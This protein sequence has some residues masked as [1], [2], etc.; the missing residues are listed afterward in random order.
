[1][2]TYY[3]LALAN[4]ACVGA[5]QNGETT[6]VWTVSNVHRERAEN[7]QVCQ[8]SLLIRSSENPPAAPPVECAFNVHAVGELD[9]D[10]TS[11]DTVDCYNGM[12]S[13]RIG[14]GWSDHRFTVMS[15]LSYGENAHAYFGFSDDALNSGD[16]I[17]DQRKSTMPLGTQ[18]HQ[19]VLRRHNGRTVENIPAWS[20]HDL[21]RSKAL[22][23]PACA[24]TD[25]LSGEH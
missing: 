16:Q 4:L 7:N 1:M 9:C 25:W 12:S 20:I 2:H 23:E 11:F 24:A 17:L 21:F 10:K 8:W 15:I 13:Y 5:R 6:A 22:T 18:L 3:F 14:G 19:Q